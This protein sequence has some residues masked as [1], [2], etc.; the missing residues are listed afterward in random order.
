MT[1]YAAPSTKVLS[2]VQIFFDMKIEILKELSGHSGCQILLC[3]TNNNLFVRKISSSPSYNERLS[4]QCLKQKHIL[5]TLANVENVAT[6]DIF[7]DGLKEDCYYFDMEYV[8]GSSLSNI[9]PSLNVQVVKFLAHKFAEILK[10]LS[11][12]PGAQSNSRDAFIKKASSIKIPENYPFVFFDVKEYLIG[13]DYGSI[14]RASSCLGDSTLENFIVTPTGKLYILDLLD[15]FYDSWKI[16]ASKLLFDLKY[17]WSCRK[18]GY[19]SN[20]I[21]RNKILAE[22]LKNN[23]ER[24][25]LSLSKTEEKDLILLHI[26]RIVPYCKDDETLRF[27]ESAAELTIKGNL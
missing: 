25:G 6:P 4:I 14:G 27:L 13:A 17:N 8:Q 2:K 11:E 12:I 7:S 3:K 5:E 24:F 23:L 22:E 20:R 15:S 19:S 9:M 10:A 18:E 21:V 26:L 16:D 1:V